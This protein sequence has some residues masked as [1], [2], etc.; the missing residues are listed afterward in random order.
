MRQTVVCVVQYAM[1]SLECDVCSVQCPVNIMMQSALC[2]KQYNIFSM[3]FL[4]CSLHCAVRNS[5]V[6][7]SNMQFIVCSEQGVV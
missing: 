2:K 7:V 5:L 3:Q 4:L 1:Y 6:V